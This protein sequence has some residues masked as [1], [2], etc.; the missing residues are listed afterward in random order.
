MHCGDCKFWDHRQ[1]DGIRGECQI[2]QGETV[3]DVRLSNAVA[4]IPM[5]ENNGEEVYQNLITQPGFG[6]ILF[7]SKHR[8]EERT[9]HCTEIINQ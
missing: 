1:V 8:Q 7:E 6:C 5:C 9:G 4:F 3:N 2:I